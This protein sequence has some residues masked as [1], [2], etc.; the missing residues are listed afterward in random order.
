MKKEIINKIT[1]ALKE[2]EAVTGQTLIVGDR[3]LYTNVSERCLNIMGFI[4]WW[5][6]CRSVLEYTPDKKSVTE[7]GNII[8]RNAANRGLITFP[9]KVTQPLS[10][11][12]KER[13]E[14]LGQISDY[15][16]KP[17]P[18]FYGETNLLFGQEFE[19]EFANAQDLMNFIKTLTPLQKFVYFKEDGSLTWPAVEIVTHPCSFDVATSLC[20][21]ITQAAIKRNA[22]VANCGHHV[23]VS[24]CAFTEKEV[25]A[26][27]ENVHNCWEEV[28]CFSGRTA[29]EVKEFCADSFVRNCGRYAAVNTKNATTVEVRVMKARLNV[30]KAVDNLNFVKRLGDSVKEGNTISLQSWLRAR[31]MAK[32]NVRDFSLIPWSNLQVSKG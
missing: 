32:E 20:R 23:H 21:D 28:I 17:E 7:I 22:M 19:F 10:P 11:A 9:G 4:S 27:V 26:M 29:D 18:I 12:D 16:Y 6:F 31:A 1:N 8:N 13:A 25:S 14:L 30:D 2:H 5:A 15:G 3:D 24:R